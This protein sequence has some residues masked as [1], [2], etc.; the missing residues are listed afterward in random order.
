MTA[1]K[2]S[3]AIAAALRA[4]IVTLASG[5]SLMSEV[6]DALLAA[7]REALASKAGLPAS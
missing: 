6:P 3:A 5:H 1:P 4:R 2:Q 7:V